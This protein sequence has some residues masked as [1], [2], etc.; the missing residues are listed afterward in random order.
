[1]MAKRKI[2]VEHRIFQDNWKIEFFCISSK[3]IFNINLV[4]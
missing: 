2:E 4:I 1:M 3:K